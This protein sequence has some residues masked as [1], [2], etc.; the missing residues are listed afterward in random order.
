MMNYRLLRWI[1]L[2]LPVAALLA[3]A[4]C[5]GDTR[6]CNT[7]PNVAGTWTLSFEDGELP[8]ECEQLGRTLPAEPLV[9]QQVG[10]ALTTELQG[11]QMT[12]TLYD[13]WEYT[14]FGSG[15]DDAGSRTVALTGRY[16]QPLAA[17]DAGERL[18]GNY[19]ATYDEGE[20]TCVLTRGYTAQRAP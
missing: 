5:G 7:C 9:L 3:S 15:D 20:T 19:N 14:V 11:T 4:A 10:S 8:P 16:A 13:T 2:A 18:Q 1:P 12:G 6:A 17:L